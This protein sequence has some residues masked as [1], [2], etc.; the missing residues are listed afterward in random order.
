MSDI[1]KRFWRSFVDSPSLGDD[2]PTKIA[3]EGK[4]WGEHLRIEASGEW[5]A[6]LDHSLIAEHYRQR[7]LIDGLPW[8]H[9]VK[10]ELGGPARKS[11]DL[12]CGAGARSLAVFRAEASR[13]V[14]GLDVSADRIDEAEKRRKE[15]GA[16]GRFEFSDVNTIELPF[17]TYDLIFSC[18][19]FHHFHAL[20]HI[21]LQVNRALTPAVSLFLRS[22]WGQVNFSGRTSR[23]S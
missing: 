1:F 3:T 21:M 7:A 6:W 13:H 12:G 8:D 10:K 23:S 22:M 17:D 18:H 4:R 11:L 5:N 20:E 2:Y 15:I 16:P 9:W 14:E 19:S